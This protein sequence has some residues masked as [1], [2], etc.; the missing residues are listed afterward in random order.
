ML[1]LLSC[2]LELYHNCLSQL[3]RD[4]PTYFQ[5]QSELQTNT[6]KLAKALRNLAS[7]ET[8]SRLQ[9]A[10]FFCCHAYENIEKEQQ[11]LLSASDV[12]LRMLE[13]SKHLIAAPFKVSY[14]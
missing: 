5:K 3:K 12:L 13:E 14:W 2:S 8:D 11:S 10:I 1:L 4:V 6:K 9:S 7:S